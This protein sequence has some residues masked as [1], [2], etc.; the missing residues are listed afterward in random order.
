MQFGSTLN[1]EV[2]RYL[3]GA[4]DNE[5]ATAVRAFIG[6]CTFRSSSTLGI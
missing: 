6:Q 4:I 2:E 3:F 5:G 1:D